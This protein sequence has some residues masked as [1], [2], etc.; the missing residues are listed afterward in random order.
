V[1]VVA[2]VQQ[3]QLLLEQAQAGAASVSAA[4]SAHVMVTPTKQPQP[5]HGH[6]SPVQTLQSPNAAAAT[7]A[8]STPQKHDQDSAAP[9]QPPHP[10]DISDL[11]IQGA[12]QV[13]ED[14]P[15]GSGAGKHTEYAVHV[16]LYCGLSYSVSRRYKTFYELDQQL[17]KMFPSITLPQLPPRSLFSSS[18]LDQ[19]DSRCAALNRYVKVMLLCALLRCLGLIR[20]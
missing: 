11:T 7:P 20:V 19:M 10:H 9:P 16:R 2:Q 12:M 4:R 14:S 6:T 18:I 8:L 17:Q 5:T 1:T 3:L 15:P 13:M